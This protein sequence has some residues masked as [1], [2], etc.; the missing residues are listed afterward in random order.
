MYYNHMEANTLPPPQQKTTTTQFPC[1]KCT[2]ICRSWNQT[3][4]CKSSTPHVPHG[5][6]FWF[7]F[8]D[9]CIVRTTLFVYKLGVCGKT[10]SLR[11]W[12]GGRWSTVLVG[13]CVGG[14]KGSIVVADSVVL[15][16]PSVCFFRVLVTISSCLSMS[17]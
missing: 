15:G 1:N 2:T 13:L 10:N 6:I 16:R 9:Y 3:P 4:Q 17:Y 12:G 7:T 8:D 11:G 14:W 5:I